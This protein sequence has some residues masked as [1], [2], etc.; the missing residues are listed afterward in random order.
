MNSLGGGNFWL[1]YNAKNRELKGLNASGRAGE[2][3]TIDFYQDRGY[4]KIPPRGYLAANTVPGV[5]SGWQE[6]HNY[7]EAT[8]FL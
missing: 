3:A 4:N 5:I 2:K 8:M 6:A 1:I 7:A